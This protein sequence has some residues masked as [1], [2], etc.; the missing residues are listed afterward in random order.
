ML[1]LD[2]IPYGN[3]VS[4]YKDL[5]EVIGLLT[6]KK[7]LFIELSTGLSNFTFNL[8]LPSPSTFSEGAKTS[9]TL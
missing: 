8:A 5:G 4:K 6:K 3:G 9:I 2:K 1:P 7:S